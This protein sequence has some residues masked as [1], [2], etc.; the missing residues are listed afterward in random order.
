MLNIKEKTELKTLSKKLFGKNSF[1][2]FSEKE[3]QTKN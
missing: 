3:K 2:I 1:V